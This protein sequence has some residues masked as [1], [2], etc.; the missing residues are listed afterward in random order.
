MVKSE[1]DEDHNVELKGQ[2]MGRGG[3]RRTI[4]KSRRKLFLDLIL[5]QTKTKTRIRD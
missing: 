4:H 3:G 2:D 1:N 5:I